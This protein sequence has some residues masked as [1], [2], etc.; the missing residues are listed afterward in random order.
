DPALGA[1]EPRQDGA[2][3]LADVRG[4]WL[5]RRRV[6]LHRPPLLARRA[7][8]RGWLGLVIEDDLL[9]CPLVRTGVAGSGRGQQCGGVLAGVERPAQGVGAPEQVDEV[10]V[11]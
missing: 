9:T 6:L 2:H 4:A 8:A 1:R 5:L 11:P 3:V 10:G 7:R